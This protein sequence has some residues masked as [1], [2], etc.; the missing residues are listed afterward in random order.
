MYAFNTDADSTSPDKVTLD[1]RVTVRKRKR[2]FRSQG[3]STPQHWPNRRFPSR[4]R[5]PTARRTGCTPSGRY[6]AATRAELGL[7]IQDEAPLRTKNSA[8]IP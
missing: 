8:Q 7:S 4:V 3:S 5:A 6:I 1:V 2:V